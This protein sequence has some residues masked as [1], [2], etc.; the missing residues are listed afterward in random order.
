[1]VQQQLEVNAEMLVAVTQDDLL[2]DRQLIDLFKLLRMEH[3]KEEGL[4][5][6]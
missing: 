5:L 4:N 2:L 1:M 3:I 6:K